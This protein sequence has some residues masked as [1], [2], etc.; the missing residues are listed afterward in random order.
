MFFALALTLAIACSKPKPADLAAKAAK[1]YF[2]ELIAG[3]FSAFLD[4]QYAANEV[5][6]EYRKQLLNNL[7]GFIVQQK[8][9]HSGIRE[10]RISHASA[11]SIEG[12]A[13]V[14]LVF[15]YGDSTTEEV[16]VPMRERDGV[17]YVK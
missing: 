17:W 10:I 11:D 7:R 4:A 3:N 2:D 8:E 5:P 9:E 1:E 12:E 14:Y 6:P 16:L 13:D 15:C